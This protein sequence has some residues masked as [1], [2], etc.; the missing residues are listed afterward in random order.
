MFLLA[1]LNETK[2]LDFEDVVVLYTECS[3]FEL[4][5]ARAKHTNQRTGAFDDEACIRDVMRAH[6]V[7]WEGYVDATGT[8]IP[9]TPQALDFVLDNLA[10]TSLNRLDLAITANLREGIESGKDSEIA[11]NG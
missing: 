5:R 9:F 2:R 7:G 11:S 8:P 10:P 6:I 1:N 3:G 4:R